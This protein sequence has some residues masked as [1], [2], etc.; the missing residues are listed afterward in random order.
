MATAS[1]VKR[2]NVGPRMSQGVVHNGTV[3]LAGLVADD[4]KADVAGQTKQILDKIDALLKTCGSSNKSI[5]MATIW[6]SDI[7][8]F[9][10]MNSVWD[11]WIPQGHTPSR[12]CI[13]SKLAFPELK[14]EIRVVAAT[15]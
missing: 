6:L 9:N 8:T 3:Y 11:K 1:P 7:G 5:L 13:E 14:V 10:E 12:A 4:T 15:E 2:F